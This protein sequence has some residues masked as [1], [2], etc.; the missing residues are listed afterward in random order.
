[1]F[2]DNYNP[3]VWAAPQLCNF[4]LTC[5]SLSVSICAHRVT[6]SV[7]VGRERSCCAL[8]LTQHVPGPQ[9]EG[10]RGLLAQTEALRF[11]KVVQCLGGH[12]SRLSPLGAQRA[13]HCGPLFWTYWARAEPW[14]RPLPQLPQAARQLLPGRGQCCLLWFTEVTCSVT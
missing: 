8:S 14:A 6:S 4:T 1:M 5:L 9:P 12:R 3:D 10:A 2:G 13:T 7:C 11:G